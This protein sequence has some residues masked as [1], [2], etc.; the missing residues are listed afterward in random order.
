MNRDPAGTCRRALRWTALLLLA[1]IGAD[2]AADGACWASGQLG[3]PD[4]SWTAAASGGSEDPCASGCVPDCFCC[5]TS[6]A[7]SFVIAAAPLAC[8]GRVAGERQRAVPAGSYRLPIQPP[9]ARS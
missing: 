7:Q 5:S 2:L 3:A 1:L 4:T 8:A 6:E 9:I